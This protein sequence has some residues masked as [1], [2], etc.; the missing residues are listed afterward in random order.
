M[1][2]LIESYKRQERGGGVFAVSGNEILRKNLD[3]HFD[4]GR[5]RAI[6]LSLENDKFAHANRVEEIQVIYRGCYRLP[7]AVA[8]RGNGPG[9]IN[10]V[11]DAS[12]QNITECIG[13][14]RKDHFDH[15]GA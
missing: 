1:A 10:Q 15:F 4:R 8:V 3:T 14:L 9:N 12:S 13:V 7:V 5:E 6:H 2:G 11:H